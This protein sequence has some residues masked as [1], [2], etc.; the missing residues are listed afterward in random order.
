MESAADNLESSVPLLYVRAQ[1]FLFIPKTKATIT[2][3]IV[4]PLLTPGTVF[5]FFLKLRPERRY[6][7]KER[8]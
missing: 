1:P 2:C 3:C 8:Q 7:T 6:R 4:P 5:Q